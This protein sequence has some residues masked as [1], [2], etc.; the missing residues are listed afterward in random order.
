[1]RKYQI[2][3]IAGVLVVGVAVKMFFFAVPSVAAETGAIKGASMDVSHLHQNVVYPAP[4][5][6]HDMTFVYSHGD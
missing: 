5:P 6:T 3:A 1:M 2:L 4:H